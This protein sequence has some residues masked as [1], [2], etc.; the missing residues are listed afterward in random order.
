MFGKPQISPELLM[1]LGGG[2]LQGQNLGQ[3]LGYGMQNAGNIMAVQ[4]QEQQIKEGENKTRAFVQKMF[5]DEDVSQMSPETLKMYAVQGIQQRFAKPEK[6]DF[7]TV[8]D[9]LYNTQTGEWIT[10]PA[11][12]TTAKLTD[13]MREYDKA[14]AQGFK[15]T[16]MDYQIKMKEAGRQQV[17]ID[18]G[19]K[20][21]SGYRW[22]DPNNR[23]LG[24]DPIPG[25]P[26]TTIPAELAARI[27]MADTFKKR[28]P[29]IKKRVLAGDATGPVDVLRGQTMGTNPV[30]ADI[31]SGVDAL[32]RLLTGAGM[33]IAEAEQ[34]AKRYMPGYWDDPETTI[35]K[36][37]RLNEELE[38]ASQKAMLGRGGDDPAQATQPKTQ[39]GVVDYKEFFK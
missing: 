14:L 27:G 39:D 11:G 6:P 32:Q 15:G 31:Q 9:A 3:G 12:V 20:L 24:V 34:Y 36:L 5:P 25:G 22:K 29:E 26:A 19:E 35:Q 7:K 38:A 33:N 30:Y 17:N 37:D 8:G 10:P 28:L 23:D 2:I 16:F 4:R 18:T 13:D 1:G 21:P